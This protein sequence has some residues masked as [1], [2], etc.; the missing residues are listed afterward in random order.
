MRIAL[1]F[2]L[3]HY[4][5]CNVLDQDNPL[6]KPEF[7]AAIPVPISTKSLIAMDEYNGVP[8]PEG[9]I[10]LPPD[11]GDGPLITKEYKE[12]WG[13]TLDITHSG[14]ST[15]CTHEDENGWCRTVKINNIGHVCPCCVPLYGEWDVT[16]KPLHDKD[17]VQRYY[18]Q[19]APNSIF[20]NTHE[21]FLGFNTT[22]VEDGW[23]RFRHKLLFVTG[24]E[25]K[26]GNKTGVSILLPEKEFTEEKAKQYQT[27]LNNWVLIS[28]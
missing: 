14:V 19:S 1:L 10:I 23:V 27:F 22:N 18:F 28:T 9:T 4:V 25:C 26:R 3:L 13:D 20:T 15:L 5:S 17:A 8:L 12:M 7:P 21:I 16:P 11:L 2:T 6:E 24:N